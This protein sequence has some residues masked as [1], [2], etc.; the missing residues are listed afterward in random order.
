M[1]QPS[2][3]VISSQVVDMFMQCYFRCVIYNKRVGY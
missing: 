3:G 1:G 2:R